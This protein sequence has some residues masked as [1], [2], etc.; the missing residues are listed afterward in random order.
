MLRIKF[1][2]TV[3][4][5]GKASYRQYSH[6]S[7]NHAYEAV[8]GQGMPYKKAS[9]IFSIPYSTLHDRVNGKTKLES[10]RSGPDPLLTQEEEQTLVTHIELMSSYGYGYTRTEVTVLAT[11]LAIHLG[12]RKKVDKP[13]SLRW[14]Y[15]FMTRWPELKVKKP[16]SLEIMRAK[17]TSQETVNRYFDEMEK[18]LE[19]YNLKDRPEAIYN[20]DEKG[21]VEN[22][23]PPSIVS[24]RYEVPPAVTMGKSSTT[25]VI[26]CGNA[27]G[28][29]LPPFFI[30]KGK[31]MRNEF[32]SGC[33]AG[34][35]GTISDSGWSNSDIFE[36][37][38]KEHF[39][40]YSL[41][42]TSDD[43]VL[44]L[45]DG[46]RSHV[47]LPLIQWAREN[48]IILF[49]LPAHT[50]HV[51][52]PM[53]IGCFGPFEKILNGMRHTHMRHHATSGIDKYSLCEIAC[54]AYASALTPNNL[55]ASFRKSGIYPVDRCAVN[56]SSFKP[57]TVFTSSEVNHPE[58]I[59]ATPSSSV[60]AADESIDDTTDRCTDFFR[61]AQVVLTENPKQTKKR[62][63]LS[64]IVGGKAITE[65]AVINNIK[66]HQEQQ[67]K[68]PKKPKK[69]V[70]NN[71]AKPS[72]SGVGHQ[73][74]KSHS[75]LPADTN[76][77]DCDESETT[78]PKDLCCKCKRFQPAELRNIDTLVFVSWAQCTYPDCC[79]WVHLRYCTPVRVVRTH[80]KFWC[81]CHNQSEE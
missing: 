37:Y 1:P 6:E 48:N 9:R 51:L 38:L 64:A 62:N 45:Y 39:M 50:S 25:T 58:N 19:K 14:F 23:T 26:G 55:Q 2:V 80:S 13:L 27:L 69:S 28:M 16:R 8:V 20:V 17:A 65:D 71:S 29:A 47:S 18:I 7:F 10:T 66:K 41:P 5:K 49:V 56:P 40:K 32:L 31:R 61:T 63:V 43:P 73:K 54:K 24:S 35:G 34:T 53:D 81:P 11:D 21:I 3:I 75:Q 60:T 12:K 4:S 67:K 72:T 57:A 36:R 77:E 44:L 52:Q 74:R 59:S 70:S 76:D 33:T 30:F 78:D 46:H 22:H 15:N 68:K 79:H 42:A